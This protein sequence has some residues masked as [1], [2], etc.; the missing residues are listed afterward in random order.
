VKFC[1]VKVVTNGEKSEKRHIHKKLKE[2]VSS[3]FAWSTR[4]PETVRVI[5]EWIFDNQVQE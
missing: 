5:W 1:R 3:C 4:A 2:A